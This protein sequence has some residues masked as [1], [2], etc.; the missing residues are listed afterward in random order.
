MLEEVW[1]GFTITS[2]GLFC[3]KC[4]AETRVFEN[5]HGLEESFFFNIFEV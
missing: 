4:P 3:M 1:M 5:V 2:K